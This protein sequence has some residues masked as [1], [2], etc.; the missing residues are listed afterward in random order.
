M[1]GEQH[2]IDAKRLVEDGFLF[3]LK[4]FQPNAILPSVTALEQ[5]NGTSAIGDS[6]RPGIL[7]FGGDTTGLGFCTV[8]WAEE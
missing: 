6:A 5:A 1:R 4:R 8:S 3:N 7:Q 2:Q